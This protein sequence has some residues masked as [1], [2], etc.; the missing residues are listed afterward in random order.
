MK[1]KMDKDIVPHEKTEE[2][3]EKE[4]DLELEAT[5]KRVEKERRKQEKREREKKAKTDLR[6][7]MSVIASTDIY[8]QSD[9][10][11]FD[12]RTLEKLNKIDIEELDYDG[13]ESEEGEEDAYLIGKGDIVINKK[14]MDRK[15]MKQRKEEEE[16]KMGNSDDD[17]E[18]EE[19]EVKRIN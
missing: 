16:D 6:S 15:S 11:L 2:E 4:N 10:V 5:I 14:T 3:L 9:E 8:N 17:N 13:S 7:K 12:R 1:Q 18:D 19:V